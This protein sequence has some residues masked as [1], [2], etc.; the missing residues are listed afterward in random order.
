MTGGF[1]EPA[2]SNFLEDA[3][4]ETHIVAAHAWRRSLRRN[5]MPSCGGVA[6]AVSRTI[7]TLT[8]PETSSVA[9]SCRRP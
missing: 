7:G 9:P 2:N 4:V 3:P 6:T 1:T 5:H 8:Q